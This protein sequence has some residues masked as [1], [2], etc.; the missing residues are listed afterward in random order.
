MIEINYDDAT[1]TLP[2]T[3]DELDLVQQQIAVTNILPLSNKVFMEVNEKMEAVTNDVVRQ[4]HIITL[5]LLLKQKEEFYKIPSEHVHYLI[6][7]DKVTEFIF[8]DAGPLILLNKKHKR[9]VGPGEKLS[10][11]SINEILTMSKFYSAY[12]SGMDKMLWPFL[13]VIYRP[14]HKGKKVEFD[15]TNVHLREPIVKTMPISQ[16]LLTLKWYEANMKRLFDSCPDLPTSKGGEGGNHIEMILQLAK[17]G[18]FGTF[19]QVANTSAELVYI[20][21][22]RISKENN[23][24]EQ[25]AKK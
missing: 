3:W 8:K 19:D 5:Q 10:G 12:K 17:D 25:K 24:L 7:R 22:N 9:L 16:I 20:E 15:I 6:F 14:M 11:V 18:P 21:L 4:M 1:Y 2:S 23:E 13:A